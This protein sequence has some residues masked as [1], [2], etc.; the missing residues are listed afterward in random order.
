M[1][2]KE[3][4]TP[5]R[6][7]ILLVVLIL[8][9]LFSRKLVT[10]LV[11]FIIGIILAA[12]LDPVID[13]LVE[14]LRMPRS[15]AVGLT[16]LAAGSGAFALLF[17]SISRMVSEL[18]EL[19]NLLPTYGSAITELTDD[20]LDHFTRLN[21]NIPT[22]ISLN[23]QRSVEG[24]LETLEKGT[25]DLINRVLAA[26]TSLPTFLLVS[27]ISLVST[28]FIARDKDL[29]V[30]TMLRFVPH[31]WRDQVSIARERIAVDLVGYIK[32]RV[33]ILII[34]VLLS[35]TGLFIIGTRYW[36]LLALVIGILDSIPVIGP[37]IIF[38]PWV[39]VSA[40]TGD[41]N[42]AVY[43]TVLYFVIFAVHQLAEPKIMGDSVGVHPLVML[44]AIYGGIVFFG[45]WGII[46]GPFIAILVKAVLDAG[47]I[48]LPDKS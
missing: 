3:L 18:M 33:L 15:L 39:A 23:I 25:R 20:L 4:I 17:F 19:T 44:L 37:G 8:A 22:V 24:F 35:G 1:N 27:L 7:V 41:L 43:L 13:F 2:L 31:R 46:A 21:E 14:K 38:T 12:L 6:A 29:L 16:L 5:K 47:L 34:T 26:F 32:G 40:L 48:R 11:P 10:A 30:E 36:V 42:R 28:Y 45:V 9:I